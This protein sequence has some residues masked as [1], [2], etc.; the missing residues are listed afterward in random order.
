MKRLWDAYNND[1][2]QTGNMRD[3]WPA[4]DGFSSEP[5]VSSC[6]SSTSA[7][8]RA[9]TADGA[10]TEKRVGE[11]GTDTPAPIS[12]PNSSPSIGVPSSSTSTM[13]VSVDTTTT[14]PAP[15]KT[16]HASRQSTKNTKQPRK[17][18]KTQGEYVLKGMELLSSS[19]AKVASSISH[20]NDKT[21]R[22][23]A[24]ASTRVMEKLIEQQ[25]Q[26]TQISTQLLQQQQLQSEAMQQM[27]VQLVKISDKLSNN[28]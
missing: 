8:R 9:S 22:D 15:P 14:S 17:K 20:T 4:K 2:Q 1:L 24:S 16:A 18:A 19:I 26:Q 10:T 25:Q 5:F 21:L 7:A 28:Q 13:H 3:L 27:I 6:S 23:D 12:S 11:V